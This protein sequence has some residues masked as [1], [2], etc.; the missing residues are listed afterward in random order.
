MALIMTVELRP[1]YL[2]LVV[3]GDWSLADALPLVG[4]IKEEADRAE[5]RKI[6]VDALGIGGSRPTWTE[7]SKLGQEIAETLQ[8]YRLAVVARAERL[9]HSTEIVAGNRGVKMAS[10][11]SEE[12]ALQWLLQ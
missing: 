2:H 12:E 7:K 3:T 4:R 9:D 8:G 5:R 6:L 10:R 11:R 1:E